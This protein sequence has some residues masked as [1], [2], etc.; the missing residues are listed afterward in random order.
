[1]PVLNQN[2]LC[3]YHYDALDRLIGTTS[4]RDAEFQRFY[5]KSRLATEIRGATQRSVFQQGEQL[6]GEQNRQGDIVESSLLATDQMCSIL[7]VVIENRR[8]SFVYSPYGH[9]S[10]GGSLL[11]SLGF[12]GERP[13]SITGHFLLGNGYRAFNPVLMRFNSPDNLSPFGKGGLN[14]YSYCAGDPV[15]RYD[16]SG[17]SILLMLEYLASRK[18]KPQLFH[19]VYDKKFVKQ[20]HQE[21]LA[22]RHLEPEPSIRII[23][24]HKDLKYL[25]PGEHGKFIFTEDKKFIV[26]KQ[27]S[28]NY[29]KRRGID[30]VEAPHHGSLTENLKSTKVLSAGYLDRKVDGSWEVTNLSGHYKPTFESLDFVEEHMK[31]IGVSENIRLR[32]QES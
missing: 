7:Q 27:F 19:I 28:D 5:C 26:G 23:N 3:R 2:V 8:S 30:Y 14:A 10:S 6:L 16:P 20:L 22:T 21:Y 18:N 12:N 4:E 15:N 13:D 29:L 1:M 9:C 32:K 31:S 17:H 25:N 11:N 24:T